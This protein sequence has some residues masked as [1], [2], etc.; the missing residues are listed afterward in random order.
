[1]EYY[2]Y[3]L[4]DIWKYGVPM[5]EDVDSPVCC[6][7]TCMS[8]DAFKRSEQMKNNGQVQGPPRKEINQFVRIKG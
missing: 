1:M 4:K 5:W 7:L 3:L 2:A 6:G 8:R